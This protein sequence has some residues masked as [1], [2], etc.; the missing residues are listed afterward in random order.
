MDNYAYLPPV[1]QVIIWKVQLYH[2]GTEGGNLWFI[3]SLGDATAVQYKHSGQVQ[4][5]CDS[6]VLYSL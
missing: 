3:S 5:A 4:L 1:L 6:D 2:M